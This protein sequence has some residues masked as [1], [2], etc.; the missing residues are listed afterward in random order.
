MKNKNHF[1][2]YT[3]L[4]VILLMSALL[5]MLNL[6]NKELQIIIFTVTAVFY[7]AWGI[8]H[9]LLNHDLSFKIVLEYVLFAALG[10]SLIFF[11]FMGGK[12]I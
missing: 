9:H 7:V 5:L 4:V 8:L 11:V 2:Y 1:W 3:S 12:G 10:I 6:G